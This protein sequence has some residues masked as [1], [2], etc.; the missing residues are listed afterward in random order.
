MGGKKEILFRELGYENIGE[1]SDLDIDLKL[2]QNFNTQ[3]ETL[4]KMLKIHTKRQQR[5]S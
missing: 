3:F 4:K 2:F 5:K 1:Y